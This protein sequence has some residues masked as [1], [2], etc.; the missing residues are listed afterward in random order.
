[1]SNNLKR[2]P[3]KYRERAENKTKTLYQISFVYLILVERK[4]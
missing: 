1:M 2:I 3:L 4:I